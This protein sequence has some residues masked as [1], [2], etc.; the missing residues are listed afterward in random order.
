MG[1]PIKLNNTF[2]T[3]G[4]WYVIEIFS[5][6]HGR[7]ECKVS[8]EDFPNVKNIRWG[9]SGKIPHLYVFGYS[10]GKFYSLSRFIMGCYTLLKVDHINHDTLDNRKENLRICTH[11]EN[12]R[13]QRRNGNKGI[14]YSNKTKTYR[15]RITV[16]NITICI[17]NYSVEEDAIKA[18]GYASKF[19]H[20]EFSDAKV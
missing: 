7:L 19:F 10:E 5:K 17:G 15:V 9:V 6:V 11:S 3:L 18:Y 1:R 12:L 14:S 16:D 20:G 4:G 8:K 2:L 13:N